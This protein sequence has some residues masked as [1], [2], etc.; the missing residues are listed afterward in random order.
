MRCEQ[1]RGNVGADSELKPLRE[2]LEEHILYVLEE[3]HYSEEMTARVLRISVRRL[4]FLM[5]RLGI[6]G[7]PTRP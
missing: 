3:C 5:R 6:E 2:I 4:R 7:W 1:R